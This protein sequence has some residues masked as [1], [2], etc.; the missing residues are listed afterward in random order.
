MHALGIGHGD[1]VILADTNWVATAA[2]ILHLGAKPV[3]VDIL[4]NTWCIDP[5]KVEAAITKTKAIIAVHIYGNLCDMDRLLRMGKN[6]KF[7]LLKML[8]KQ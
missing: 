7:Q 3:Y 6:I 1:E 5:D 2:P 8:L 4:P